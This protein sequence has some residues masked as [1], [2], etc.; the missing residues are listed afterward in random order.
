MNNLS[1]SLLQDITRD[2]YELA[3]QAK[4]FFESWQEGKVYIPKSAL[5]AMGRRYLSLRDKPSLSVLELYEFGRLFA[6]FS[7]LYPDGEIPS[8]AD[9]AV[10]YCNLL[11]CG[12]P[13]SK[14]LVS[15]EE[16]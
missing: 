4:E 11:A 6:F 16:V 9:V 15:G 14:S 8:P 2:S 5:R 12:L 7:L 10:T 3:K 1:E 13:L